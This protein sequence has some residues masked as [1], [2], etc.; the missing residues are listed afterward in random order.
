MRTSRNMV[1]PMQ[2]MAKSVLAGLRHRWLLEHNCDN[3]DERHQ[4]CQVKGWL[5]FLHVTSRC[6]EV[7]PCLRPKMALDLPAC[8]PCLSEPRASLDAG[9]HRTEELVLR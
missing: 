4:Y 9:T 3:P 8:I 1:G 6:Q 2:M 7:S 5:I